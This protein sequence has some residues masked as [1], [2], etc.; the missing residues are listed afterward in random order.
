MQE[1]RKASTPRGILIPLTVIAHQ[2]GHRPLLFIRDLVVPE[3]VFIIEQFNVSI[4]KK[5]IVFRPSLNFLLVFVEELFM[6]RRALPIA[7]GMNCRPPAGGKE[8]DVSWIVI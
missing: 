7:F 5:V 2:M 1:M 6:Y 4:P 3:S 8:S